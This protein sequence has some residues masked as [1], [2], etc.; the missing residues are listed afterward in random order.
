M[1][2]RN[3]TAIG[4]KEDAV[5]TCPICDTPKRK[6]IEKEYN[7][8]SPINGGVI[9]LL[10]LF[11]CSSCGFHYLDSEKVNQAWFD[12]YYLNVYQTDDKP[13]SDQRLNSL[14]DCVCQFKQVRALDIGGVDKELQARITA[15]GNKC[16]V[17]GVGDHARRAYNAVIL[18]HTLEHIYDIPAMMKRIKAA[19]YP[20]GFLFIE[21]PV[22]LDYLD[23]AYDKHWQH[24]QKFR[25]Q[26]LSE[27]LNN[28]GF[29]VEVSE[30]L[31]DYR[32]YKVWRIVGRYG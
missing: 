9:P 25:P 31:P 11:E 15:R 4:Q 5:R 22:H 29:A 3:S 30:Q 23:K 6:T 32:E 21:V 19:L 10:S 2:E 17:A 27:L 8:S 26:D 1:S 20:G 24:I 13:H 14:A 16:D 18:S 28:N 12:W 7:Y